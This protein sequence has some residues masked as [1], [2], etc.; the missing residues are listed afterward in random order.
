MIFKEN[1]LKGNSS[2]TFS[3]LLK[4]RVPIDI[5][6]N[7][8]TK[9]ILWLLLFK[10]YII[11]IRFASRPMGFYL[12][13]MLLLLPRNALVIKNSI[14]SLS[15]GGQSETISMEIFFLHLY[16][17]RLNGKDFYFFKSIV[18]RSYSISTLTYT[19]FAFSLSSERL[20]GILWTGL[21]LTM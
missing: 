9:R 7:L 13:K 10:R 14:D 19:H 5:T 11:W 2:V 6:W 12:L 18:I 16:K 21:L 20:S 17:M 1:I 15:S 4:M 3:E 8:L